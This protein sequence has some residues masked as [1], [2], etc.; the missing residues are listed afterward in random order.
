MITVKGRCTF[1]F[2]VEIPVNSFE[3]IEEDHMSIESSNI[4]IGDAI[5]S[6]YGVD[7]YK[8]WV[9]PETNKEREQL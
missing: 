5:E 7:V 6:K 2:E 4:L 1:D 3:D 9:A 8:I